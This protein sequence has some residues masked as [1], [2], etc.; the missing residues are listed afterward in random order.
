MKINI[1]NVDKF[2]E[3]N[4]LREVSDPV[5]LERDK[6]P[7]TNGLFSYEIFGRLGSASR[8]TTFAYIDLKGHYLHP[9]VYKNLKRLDRKIEE[10]IMGDGTFSINENGELVRD[11]NGENGIDFLYKNWSKLK[12][13]K[14][15]SNER[16]ERV[17]MIESLAKNE[18]F[19]SKQIVMPPLT[20]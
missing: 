9:L 5:L 3:V 12:F 20:I 19:M 15:Q 14:T 2:V 18:I 8:K 13:K 17:R 4:M 6:T 11:V 7:T 16:N 1:F 10:C